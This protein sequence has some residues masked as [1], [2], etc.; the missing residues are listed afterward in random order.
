[1]MSYSSY[2]TDSYKLETYEPPKAPQTVKEYM[3]ER[4]EDMDRAIPYIREWAKTEEHYKYLME[5]PVM[6]DDYKKMLDELIDIFKI[7]IEIEEES[8]LSLK[9]QMMRDYFEEN[10]HEALINI[11]WHEVCKRDEEKFHETMELELIDDNCVRAADNLI[12]KL[13]RVQTK[14]PFYVK[15]GRW[16]QNGNPGK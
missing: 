16:W 10:G 14:A 13:E 3:A 7:K 2:E 8:I 5:T 15:I 4:F 11:F 1:M 6:T 12:S 9:P